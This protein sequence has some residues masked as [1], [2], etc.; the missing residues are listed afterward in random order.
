[1]EVE[2]EEE[3]GEA[4]PDTPRTPEGTGIRVPAT[5]GGATVPV[6]MVQSTKN[7]AQNWSV[8]SFFSF[9]FFSFFFHNAT[10]Q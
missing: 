5:R 10:C 6:A 1:M 7:P 2:E 8:E 3:E 9:L 4:V